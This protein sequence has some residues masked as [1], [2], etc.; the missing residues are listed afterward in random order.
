MRLLIVDGNL[1]LTWVVRRLAPAVE[2][3]S[4]ATRE[5]VECELRERPPDAVLLNVR[6]PA[7]PWREVAGLCRRH[8]PPIPVLFHAGAHVDPAEL[9]IRTDR[10]SFFTESLTAGDLDRLLE[11]VKN[12]AAVQ[13]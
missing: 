10:R 1:L 11:A 12:G 13:P 9:G 5:Q 8:R 4:A 6:R 2:V 3:E 7:G